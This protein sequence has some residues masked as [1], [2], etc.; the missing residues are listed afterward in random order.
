MKGSTLVVDNTKNTLKV[1][2]KDICQSIQPNEESKIRNNN[3]MNTSNTSTGFTL[4][5]DGDLILQQ[6]RLHPRSGSRTMNGSRNTVGIIGDLQSGLNNFFGRNHQHRETCRFTT[7]NDSDKF[8]YLVQVVVFR[9]PATSNSEAIDGRCE[10]KTLSRCMYRRR[11]LISTS[12]MMLHAH[13]W[14]KLNGVPKTF[15][16]SI[17]CFAPCLTPCTVYP[18]FC[19]LFHFPLLLLLSIAQAHG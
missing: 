6:V 7:R 17:S 4:E 16:H 3:L 10:Q 19:P 9:L 18:A 11:H 13:A 15:S 2:D 5:L 8:F 12:H 1:P 14:L